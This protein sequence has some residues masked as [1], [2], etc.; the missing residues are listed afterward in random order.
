MSQTLAS[1]AG[2][3][4]ATVVAAAAQDEAGGLF[5]VSLATLSRRRACPPPLLAELDGL[6]QTHVTS[7]AKL[8]LILDAASH[9]SMTQTLADVSA[10]IDAQG[11]HG[12]LSPVLTPARLGGKS[13]A[14]AAPALG[15]G[16][17]L[18]WMRELP[19]PPIPCESYC[20]VL[21]ATSR[22]LAT[23]LRKKLPAH[24]A[25]LVESLGTLLGRLLLQCELDVMAPASAEEERATHA[26]LS[27][28]APALLR[29]TPTSV[30][31]QPEKAAAIRAT[32]AF[33]QYHS[34]RQRYRALAAGGRHAAAVHESSPSA[35]ST[36]SDGSAGNGVSSS[37]ADTPGSTPGRWAG[38]TSSSTPASP[39][40]SAAAAASP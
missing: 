14:E 28:L 7:S 11:A 2:S 4:A 31:P 17:L 18:R 25:K 37:P 24:H 34:Q 21:S 8:A 38:A 32:R 30:I 39:S 10:A 15:L 9:P 13:L 22:T 6:L 40:C 1:A 26:L 36:L 19:S 20:V 5:G 35:H 12:V 29:P 27:A 23:V 3:L 33:L 16:V